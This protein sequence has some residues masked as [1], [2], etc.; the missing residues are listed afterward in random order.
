MIIACQFGMHPPPPPFHFTLL[1]TNSSSSRKKSFSNPF[2]ICISKKKETKPAFFKKDLT[3]IT[4]SNTIELLTL[5]N[6]LN[7]SYRSL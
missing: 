6:L 3:Y 2:F 4:P 5:N 1:I 7:N